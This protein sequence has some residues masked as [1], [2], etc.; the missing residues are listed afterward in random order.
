M[1]TGYLWPPLRCQFASCR[2]N[3]TPATHGVR[4][5]DY[6]A[7]IACC[8]DHIDAARK[9]CGPGPCIVLPLPDAGEP[10]QPTLY[11]QPNGDAA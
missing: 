11:D 1:T 3:G 4:R 5:V 8:H 9:W 6:T 2:K 10:A 7:S